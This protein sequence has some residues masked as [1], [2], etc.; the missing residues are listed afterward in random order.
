MAPTDGHGTANGEEA[1]GAQA[2]QRRQDELQS[3]AAAVLAELDLLALLGR[4]GD[5]LLFGSFALGVMVWRDID[6]HV[7]CDDYSADRCFE[8][9]RPLASHPG[10][11]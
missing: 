9:M 6:L 3:E 10:V 2:L 8:A 11:K 5:P 4:V 7:Y 1:V